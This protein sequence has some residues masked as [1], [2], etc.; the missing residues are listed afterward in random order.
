MEQNNLRNLAIIAH[1]DHGKT[2]LVNGMLKQSG[3]FH[4]RQQI[5]D[6]VLDSNELEKERGITIL[7]KNTSIPF[8]EYKFNIVD[9]P[10][11]ADFGGEVERI[12]QMVD[13][14]LLVVDAFEGPMPQTRFV[15]S[16][17]LAAKLKPIVVIN[18]I[19]RPN[20]RPKEVLDQVLDLF[21][22]LAADDSQLDF[23]VV[24]SVAKN[25]VATLDLDLPATDLK[26]LFETIIA[27]IPAPGGDLHASFQM[28]IAMVEQDSYLGRKGIGRIANGSVYAK[29][30]VVILNNDGSERKGQITGVFTF[31]G[32]KEVSAKNATCGEIVLVTGLGDLN[33]GET[34]ADVD[35][36]KLLPMV[37]IDEPTVSITFQ[38]NKSPFAGQ[39]GQYI[40][41][42]RLGERL[43]KEAKGDVSLRVA[44]T[45][46]PE[47]FQV[48]GRGELHLSIL[49]EKMRREG[50]EFE[51]SRPQVIKKEVGGE[52][53]E[54]IEELYLEVEDEY[55]GFSIESL[56]VRKGELQK[57]EAKAAGWTNL[58]F[59]IPTR[60]LFGFRSEFMTGT[61]GTGIMH[62]A[63]HHFAPWRGDIM[64][65]TRGALVAF[66]TGEAT[67]YG[68]EHAQER[69]ELF[70]TPGEKT[71][72]GMI[73][74]E[75]ARPGDLLIN[76]SK[77][78]QLTNIRSS[79]S[80]IA[81]KLVP[82][83]IMGLEKSLEFIDNDELLEVTP[84]Y[85]RMRKRTI[86]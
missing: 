73:V 43:F 2:T 27:H 76:V 75:N 78:K 74:G 67:S 13:G 70:I 79:T 85:L 48:A 34:V 11:H 38:V 50:F 45:E 30:E 23:P 9:T 58:K 16:K 80:D 71:Y 29:Q 37:E 61:K 40:T 17:A 28:G 69:G 15:L 62:H 18:K 14:V 32:L 22:E 12:V 4:D 3:L 26:P 57:I 39:D 36:P 6:R 25:G 33:V 31:D 83:R 53:C 8:R 66:E 7:A 86:T 10:G 20:A 56:G 77:K 60:G 64:S 49:I 42:R 54:P 81:I 68:I 59:L 47:I 1:V 72:R 46:S 52:V 35:N 44:E 51:V 63:F 19:D 41:S 84:K 5:E 24:Y 21:I 65:R 55:V 82:P